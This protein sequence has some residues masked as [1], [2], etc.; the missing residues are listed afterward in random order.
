MRCWRLAQAVAIL[1]LVNA[2]VA[3]GATKGTLAGYMPA[4]VL[5]PRVDFT[6][7]CDESESASSSIT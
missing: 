3:D 2:G 5:V 4:F 7:P 1:L 6:E